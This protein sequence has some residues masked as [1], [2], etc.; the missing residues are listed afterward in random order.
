MLMALAI[1]S[2]ES[3]IQAGRFT[4]DLAPF[5]TFTLRLLGTLADVRTGRI[6]AF[7]AGCGKTSSFGWCV[8][9]S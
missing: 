9:Y 6:L 3:P 4:G 7:L 8:D 1:D 2:K 5:R